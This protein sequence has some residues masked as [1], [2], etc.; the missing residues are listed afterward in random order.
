MVLLG[1][2]LKAHWLPLATHIGALAPLARLVWLYGRGLFMVDPVREMTTITGRTAMVLLVLTL[3]CTPVQIVFGFAQ[4]RRVRRALGL[5]TFGYAALHFF[6]FAGLDYGF[7]LGLLGP[8]LVLQ[9]FVLV[10]LV[11]FLLL[12]PL[13]VTSTRGWQR[14]LGK[15]WRRL[16]WLFY[17]AAALVV[18]HLLWL[19][20]D[21]RMS[22]RYGAIIAVLLLVRVPPIRKAIVALR[23]RVTRDRTADPK[24]A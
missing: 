8:A 20:K 23:R 19:S 16:H 3:A 13:A 10:G 24:P 15:N 14:R 4:V 12:L 1:R 21:P 22:V 11:A 17:P 6:V 9:R 7:D 2:W 5:Y 18:V